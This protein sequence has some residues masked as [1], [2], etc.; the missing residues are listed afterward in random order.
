MFVTIN[1]HPKIPEGASSA[2]QGPSK[3]LQLLK[4]QGFAPEIVKALNSNA[5]AGI[6]GNKEDLDMRKRVY[7]ENKHLQRKIRTMCD[8]ICDVLD[9]FIL[10]V[11]IVAAI[12][13]T[14]LGM[15]KDGPKHGYQEGLGIVFAII[16]ILVVSVGNDYVKEKQF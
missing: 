15:I 10:K 7:G 14:V 9:D 8:M 3:S 1:I 16:I 11:L 12:V 4:K 13:S 6:E 5:V 2:D